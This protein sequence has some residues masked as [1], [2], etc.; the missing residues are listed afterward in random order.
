LLSPSN[1]FGLPEDRE[2]PIEMFSEDFAQDVVRGIT[3]YIGNAKIMQG[4]LII[5]AGR[6]D[7]FYEDGQVVRV[8]AIGPPSTFKDTPSEEVGAVYAQGNQVDYNLLT[9]IVVV[10]GEALFSNKGSEVSANVIEFDLERGAANATGGVRHVIQPPAQE[11]DE[12]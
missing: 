5:E 3:S 11:A 2:K 1:A 4:S 10:T 9:N 7:V 8:L 12:E 6:I